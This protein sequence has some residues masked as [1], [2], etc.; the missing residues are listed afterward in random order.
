[1][2]KD[3]PRRNCPLY[4]ELCREVRKR[5]GNKCQFPGCK[6][7]KYLEVHHI[8]KVA[9]YPHLIYE[10]KNCLLL[11]WKC[12]KKVTGNEESYTQ[13]FQSIVNKKVDSTMNNN[14]LK[15]LALKFNIK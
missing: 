9:D 6:R 13:L 10:K 2:F 12:H 1:M 15:L 4:T 5:D 11:C 8:L 14:D 7:R 3:D